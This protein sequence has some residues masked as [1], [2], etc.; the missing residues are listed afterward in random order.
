M[1]MSVRRAVLESDREALIALIRRHLAPQSDHGRFDWLYLHNPDGPAHAWLAQ[2]SVTGVAVGAAAAFPKKVFAGGKERLSLVLGDFCLDERYRALGPALRLQ[3]ACLESL[4]T[5]YDFCYDFPSRNMMAIY[6]RLGIEQTGS[7]ARWTKPLR[8]EGKL[9]SLSHSKALARGLGLIANV[10]L[11]K[12]G[13]KGN[14]EACEVTSQ[15]APFGKEFDGLDPHAAPSSCSVRTARTAEYL[16]WRD[17]MNP[18]AECE[19]LVARKNG[20]LLGFVVF[21]QGAKA[22]TI[23]DLCSI[24]DPSVVARLLAAAVERCRLRGATAVNMAAGDGHPCEAI[25][26]RAGFVRRESAPVIALVRKD[27]PLAQAELNK[28]WYLMQGDRDV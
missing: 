22:A 2:D 28:S 16:N 7:I 6:N 9:E 11:A 14:P 19:T 3:R 26:R 5:P 27:G 10:V 17:R 15:E 24:Q 21:T 12:R 4:T 20:K 18:V 25:F 13:Y 1:A 23:V 8:V